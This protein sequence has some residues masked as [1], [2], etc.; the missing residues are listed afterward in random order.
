MT[1]PIENAVL[2]ANR[3]FYDA[4]ADRNAGAMAQ[5]WARDHIVMCIHP[6]WTP[7]HGRD[8]VIGSWRSILQSPEPPEVR[9][10]DAAAV[11]LGGDVALVTCVEH[12][13]ETQIAA[14]NVFALESGEWRLVHHHAGPVAI[15]DEP[16]RTSVSPLN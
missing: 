11:V 16:R 5:L 2:T 9:F 13:G 15:R 3:A 7:L 1:S 6:G 10:T 12:V 4:F 8:A 14:T